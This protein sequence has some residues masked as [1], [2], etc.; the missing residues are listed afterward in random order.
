MNLPSPSSR[1]T[2]G[3]LV[4][5]D[6]S[7]NDSFLPSLPASQPR[8]VLM[9]KAG[10]KREKRNTGSLLRLSLGIC[11]LLL[12]STGRGKSRVPVQRM[13]KDTP[14]L[15]GQ[16]YKSTWQGGVEQ[17]GVKA[18]TSGPSCFSSSFH[19]LAKA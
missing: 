6:F 8:H 15:D 13:G 5:N 12:Y 14:S 17:G 4:S 3:R 10:T 16:S 19:E 9:A 2:R 1:S 7:R 18:V 11:N